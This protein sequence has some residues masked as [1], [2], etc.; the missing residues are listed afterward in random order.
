M[1]IFWRKSLLGNSSLIRHKDT[2]NKSQMSFIC[3]EHQLML[4]QK[5]ET[6]E[7]K[8]SPENRLISTEYMR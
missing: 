5:A 6:S 1:V 2:M 7:T 4:N 8:L 3:L